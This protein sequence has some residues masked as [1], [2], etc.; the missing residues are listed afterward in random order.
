MH[1]RQDDHLP[2]GVTVGIFFV[3]FSGFLLGCYLAPAS[4]ASSNRLVGLYAIRP[5]NVE[6]VTSVAG[7]GV[8]PLSNSGH[9]RFLVIRNKGPPKKLKQRKA[10]HMVWWAFYIGLKNHP[11]GRVVRFGL[12]PSDIRTGACTTDVVTDNP[13]PE[14]SR[15]LKHS[16]SFVVLFLSAYWQETKTLT[17]FNLSYIIWFVT[18]SLGLFGVCSKR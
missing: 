17:N 2:P 10:H 3:A 5:S 18:I 11:R 6:I 15:G 9:R 16:L 4:V 8:R 13:I 1:Y 12:V 14:S 7:G